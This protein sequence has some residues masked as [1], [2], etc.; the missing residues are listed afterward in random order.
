MKPI[1]NRSTIAAPMRW[2]GSSRRR[3]VMSVAVASATLFA[4]NW[5]WRRG[6]APSPITIDLSGTAPDVAELI[7]SASSAVHRDPHSAPAWGR[8]GMAL[9][10]NQFDQEARTCMAEAQRLDPSDPRWPYLIGCCLSRE[11]PESALLP[12]ERAVAGFGELPAP[13]LRLAELLLSLGRL[14]EAEFHFQQ[15]LEL[16]ERH[17]RAR[18]GLAR[19]ALA[20]G[21]PKTALEQ[22]RQAEDSHWTRKAHQAV[23]LEIHRQMSDQPR[24]ERAAR[25][26]AELPDDADMP[27][28]IYDE[29]KTLGRGADAELL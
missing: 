6:A 9:L 13:R 8:L 23:L 3:V 28:P 2:L 20:R 16:D 4:G 27:D 14:D 1:A 12:L 29:V 26:L 18:L 15:V 21:D 10:A 7:E 17:S 19:V 22:V 5:A 24:V 25:R 11:S